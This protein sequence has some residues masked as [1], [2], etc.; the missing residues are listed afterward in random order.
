MVQLR[1]E[2][3]A[4]SAYSSRL[5]RFFSL[6]ADALN[7]AA[8]TGGVGVRA[9]S[10]QGVGVG[11]IAEFDEEFASVNF[12]GVCQGTG[13]REQHV[14][15][16]ALDSLDRPDGDAGYEIQ[17]VLG[18]STANAI[19]EEDIRIDRH[20][21]GGPSSGGRRSH[22]NGGIRFGNC[23]V[24]KAEGKKFVH[25]E[26][27]VQWQHLNIDRRNGRG[28]LPCPRSRLDGVSPPGRI[29]DTRASAFFGPLS[30]FHRD[31][32][33]LC[34]SLCLMFIAW[35][36]GHARQ[37]HRLGIELRLQSIAVL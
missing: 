36:L 17:F 37:K 30:G 14:A 22:D 10:S 19:G 7:Q 20:G 3:H 27:V 34:S 2:I 9:W 24:R 35:P 8:D 6:L 31:D 23:H 25:P 28:R 15:V 16:A 33:G 12:Q 21:E 29:F 32:V 4:E 11:L 5:R 18:Y 1:K 26:V 13:G